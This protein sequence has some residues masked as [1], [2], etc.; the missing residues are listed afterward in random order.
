MPH[1]AEAVKKGF[2]KDHQLRHRAAAQLADAFDVLVDELQDMI[3]VLAYLRHALGGD[4][5]GLHEHGE[6][7]LDG[8]PLLLFLSSFH[9]W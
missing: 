4:Y 7:R 9:G 6:V 2:G 5:L 8:R 3:E 1:G